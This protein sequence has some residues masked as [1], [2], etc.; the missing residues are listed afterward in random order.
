M[1]D[2]LL[3]TEEIENISPPTPK[4]VLDFVALN[5]GGDRREINRIAAITA[6]YQIKTAQAQLNKCRE[7]LIKEGWRQAFEWLKTQQIDYEKRTKRSYYCIEDSEMD[8]KRK[9]IMGEA[10]N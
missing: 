10:G 7:P 2:E 1:K 5:Y 3:L 9:E 4:E 8:T 6:L